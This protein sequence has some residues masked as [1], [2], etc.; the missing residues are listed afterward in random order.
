[1]TSPR[2]YAIENG[3]L[4][5][6][7]DA[8]LTSGNVMDVLAALVDKS[9]VVSEGVEEVRRYRMLETI[10]QYGRD[11]LEETGEAQRISASH[12]FLVCQSGAAD[13]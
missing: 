1:M 11:R 12:L 3:L 9:L 5:L 8:A 13:I 2:E 10:R 6:S 4:P 7:N